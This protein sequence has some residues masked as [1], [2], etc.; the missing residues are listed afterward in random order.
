M[1]HDSQA[2]GN[3][4]AEH[5]KRTLNKLGVNEPLSGDA[6]ATGD[7]L[8]LAGRDCLR[9][10]PDDR[11]PIFW[12]VLAQSAR[13]ASRLLSVSGCL[14]RALN[15]AGGMV[16]TISLHPQPIPIHPL[17]ETASA[18]ADS[19]RLPAWLLAFRRSGL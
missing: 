10:D 8:D 6:F 14:T 11:Y 4:V 9:A 16:A 5:T 17:P 2:Y 13:N 12:P 1:I 15:V 19:R 7:W 3:G 18:T